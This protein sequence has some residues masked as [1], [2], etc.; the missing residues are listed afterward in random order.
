MQDPHRTAVELGIRYSKVVFGRED[1]II[2]ARLVYGLSEWNLIVYLPLFVS[3]FRIP[4]FPVLERRLQGTT[5]EHQHP[6]IQHR[7]RW[8]SFDQLL[9]EAPGEIR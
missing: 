3:E 8:R 1:A 6:C 4:R 7:E 9:I 2:D 5:I